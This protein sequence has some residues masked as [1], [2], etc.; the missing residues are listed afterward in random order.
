LIS[1]IVGKTNVDT[2]TPP[3]KSSYEIE[4]QTE[5]EQVKQDDYPKSFQ[6]QK[7]RQHEQAYL[8]EQQFPPTTSE[9]LS[10]KQKSQLANY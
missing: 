9:F 6:S 3:T 8:K 7:Q 1:K 10:Q 4:T 5:T 2:P